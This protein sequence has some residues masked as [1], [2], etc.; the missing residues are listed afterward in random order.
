MRSASLAAV[1][2]SLSLAISPAIAQRPAPV[3]AAEGAK[4]PSIEKAKPAETPARDLE[5][6]KKLEDLTYLQNRVTEV[7][8]KVTPSVVGIQIGNSAGSGVIISEDGY[9]LTAGHV[10]GDANKDATIILPGGKRLKAKTLGANKSIDS[11]LIKIEKASGLP[12]VDLGVSKPLAKGQWVVS[13]GHPGGYQQERAPVVRLGRIISAN[14]SVIQTDCTLVGGDS[15]G[16]LFDLDGRVIGI[17]S[18]IGAGLNLNYHVP[19]DTYR[20]T[21]DRL[22]VAEVWSDSPFGNLFGGGNRQQR[23]PA[24]LGVELDVPKRGSAGILITKVMSNSPAEKA[25]LL[26]G[27]H[28]WKIGDV[29]LIK[30]VD[31]TEQMKDKRVGVEVGLTLLR[32]GEEIEKRVRLIRRPATI[33]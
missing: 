5:F 29:E 21:W 6:P 2:L 22:V 23:P 11:G 18:R 10:S 25:G 1:W 13:I 24:W 3:A 15:G 17:H 20:D 14:S 26:A 4:P 32:N 33:D 7:V 8:K 31:F 28:L 19:A 12:F 27:D 9:V 16:P 30:P